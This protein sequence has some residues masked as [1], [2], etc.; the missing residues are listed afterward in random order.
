MRVMADKVAAEDVAFDDL[1]SS[2]AA[3]AAAG[4]YTRVFTLPN[5]K[6]VTDNKSLVEYAAGQSR[7][8]PVFIQPLGAITQKTEGKEFTVTVTLS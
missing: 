7:H 8:L 3:A 5:T 1:P 4:G 6:P 2:S